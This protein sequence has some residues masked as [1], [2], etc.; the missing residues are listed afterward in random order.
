[1]T[2]QIMYENID[3]VVYLAIFNLFPMSSNI[4]VS[5]KYFNN[6]HVANVT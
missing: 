1:M 4:V 3:N 2:I 5:M 6:S